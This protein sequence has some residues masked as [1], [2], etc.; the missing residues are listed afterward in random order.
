MK[1]KQNN[2][3]NVFLNESNTQKTYESPSLS[4]FNLDTEEGVMTDSSQE[5]EMFIEELLLGGEY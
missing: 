4:C 3:K 5:E 2:L 1:N